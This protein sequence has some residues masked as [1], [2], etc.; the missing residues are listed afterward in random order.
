MAILVFS[1]PEHFIP[2]QQCLMQ[3]TKDHK[4]LRPEFDSKLFGG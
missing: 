2:L 4:Y 3:Q 1:E